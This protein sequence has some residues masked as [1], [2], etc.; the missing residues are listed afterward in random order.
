MPNIHD[1][2]WAQHFLDPSNYLR[3][4]NF[5]VD[6]VRYKPHFLCT[7]HVVSIDES[8]NPLSQWCWSCLLVHYCEDT[9][10]LQE[11]KATDAG[12]GGRANGTAQIAPT[13]TW[14][15]IWSHPRDLKLPQNMHTHFQD[16]VGTNPIARPPLHILENQVT[17]DVLF[18]HPPF[19]FKFYVTTKTLS[20]KLR[21]GQVGLRYAL[22]LNGIFTSRLQEFIANKWCFTILQL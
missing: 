20:N 4:S 6:T 5:I 18:K 3:F 17:M 13:C 14:G 9:E 15:L 16:C 11:D 8:V 7:R 21:A 2:F 10:L 19:L 1:Y 22:I 12:T